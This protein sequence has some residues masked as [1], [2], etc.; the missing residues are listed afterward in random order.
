MV[1]PVKSRTVGG[2]GLRPHAANSHAIV[3]M[4]TCTRHNLAMFTGRSV[5]RS[6]HLP[7]GALPDRRIHCPTRLGRW[8]LD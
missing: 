2:G 7:P 3:Q 4:D 1:G 5:H 6:L 8:R